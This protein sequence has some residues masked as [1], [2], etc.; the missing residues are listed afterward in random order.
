[1]SEPGLQ[2]SKPSILGELVENVV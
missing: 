2:S 1:M